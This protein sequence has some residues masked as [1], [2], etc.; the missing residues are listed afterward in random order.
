MLKSLRYRELIYTGPVDEYFDYRFGK[1][2]YRSLKF[3]HETMNVAGYQP[4]AVVNYPNEHKY[5]RV[6]EFK[7]LTGQSHAKT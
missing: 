1:L 3:Q 4:V 2:P 5:T 7:Y 6:T